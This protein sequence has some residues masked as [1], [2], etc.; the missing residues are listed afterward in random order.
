MK[1]LSFA[2]PRTGVY[3]VMV[4]PD[5]LGDQ[6]AWVLMEGMFYVYLGKSVP[7][8]T[9]GALYLTTSEKISMKIYSTQKEMEGTTMLSFVYLEGNT[10]LQLSGTHMACTLEV[11]ENAKKYGYDENIVFDG[12]LILLDEGNMYAKSSAEF[13]IRVTG[14]YILSLRG[15]PSSGQHLKLQVFCNHQVAFTSF[16]QHGVSSGQAGVFNFKKGDKLYVRAR[17]VRDV[18]VHTMISIALLY[19]EEYDGLKP[20]PSNWIS[21]IL[22]NGHLKISTPHKK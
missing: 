9:S 2:V 1:I 11:Q 5:P 19:T 12:K 22:R 21:T 6:W 4:R 14:S 15:D 20:E 10:P 7:L 3:W 17:Y 16:S 18:G 13:N 8:S